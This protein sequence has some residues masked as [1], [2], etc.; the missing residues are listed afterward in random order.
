MLRHFFCWSSKR[1]IW[2]L[3][4][5]CG[6]AF[7][8]AATVDI[9]PGDNIPNVV[10]ASPAGTTFIIYPGTYRLQAPII[11]KDN[12]TFIGQIAC[13]PPTVSCP[14][15]LSGSRVIGSLA[16][17]NGTYYEVTGQSQQGP[18]DGVTAQKCQPG[19]GGC[20]Y[21]EDLFFDGVPLQHI[22]SPTLPKIGSGHWWFD[23]AN[24]IIYFYDNP[25]GHVVETS[26]TTNAFAGLGN[27]V[28]ISQLTIKEFA[29]PAGN[30][31]T[32][33]P[34]GN[35]TLTQGIHWTIQKCEIL[36]NHGAGIRVAYR[37]QILNNYIHN[38][39][40]LGITG[41]MSTD[42]VTRTTPSLIVIANNVISYNNY[43]HFVPQFGAGGIKVCSAASLNLHGNTIT[44]NDGG[45]IHFD[46][47]DISPTVDGNTVTDNTGGGG[48]VYEVSL[49]S[50][51]FR[52]NISLRNGADLTTE[53]G[54]TADVGSYASAGVQTYCNV[55][56]IQNVAHT[57]GL[58]VVGSNR[59]Y[60]PYSPYEY[61]TSTGNAFHHNTVFWTPGA[62]GLVGYF[63]NDTT[64]QPDFFS[65]NEAPDYNMYHLP[66]LSQTVFV[67]DNNSSGQNTLKSFAQYQA[68]GADIHGSAD[69]KY[70]SSYPA[71]KITAPL[72]NST[73]ATSA[74]ITAAASDATGIA[75]VEFFVDWSLQSTV[76]SSPYTFDWTNAATGAH[77]ITAMAYNKNGIGVCYAITLN[78]L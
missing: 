39:G 54:P 78:K 43:A 73:V 59:G 27:N 11:T 50:A 7:G 69:T 30:P 75:K 5:L 66:S 3:I 61:L 29:S 32:I 49:T 21:P 48:I 10:S 56:Q 52:N 45:G 60:N 31:G 1:F 16:T 65:E 4:F 24:N 74:T 64:N 70:G 13:A 76:T 8:Y 40:Q 67:Y 44:H 9:H 77:T 72:N 20:Q 68:A 2:L 38:N 46:M 35:P 63:L 57:H 62:T 19:W 37:M 51:L 34:P 71:V 53:T 28:T 36:L 18:T 17:F 42:A 6:A 14:A 15:I 12:D 47:S 55:L 23:Y 33:G 41:G 58:L 26:V 25:A 22:D